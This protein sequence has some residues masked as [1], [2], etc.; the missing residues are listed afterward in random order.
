MTYPVLVFTRGYPTA[1]MREPFVKGQSRSTNGPV[2]TILQFTI[3]ICLLISTMV[4]IR[5][6]QFAKKTPPGVNVDHV[7]KVPLNPQLGS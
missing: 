4:V 5:Q 7:I 6:V 1:I 2:T 3:S